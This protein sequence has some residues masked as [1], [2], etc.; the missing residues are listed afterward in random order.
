MILLFLLVALLVL[1][2]VFWCKFQKIRCGNMVCI[3]G[4]IK[5]GKSML[6]V[7]LVRQLWR[8][9]RLKAHIC[10]FFGRIFKGKK[11]KKREMPVIY[12]NVPLRLPYVPLTRELLTRQ[13]R[14]IYGSVVYVCEASLVADSM[15]YKDN[16]LN[17]LLLLFNKLFAHETHGGYIVY[18]TQSICDNHYAVK[19]CLNSYFYIHH[20][21]RI[22]FFCVLFMREERYSEDNHVQNVTSE[23]ADSGY[24]VKIIPKRVWKLYDR[25]CY[26]SFTDYLIRQDGVIDGKKADSMKAINVVSFK[27]YNYLTG[28]YYERSDK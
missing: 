17:E 23:N 13:V 11:Y 6:S 5:T 10:N 21:I 24:K 1:Y 18:D 27:R 2:L 9:Q 22:P 8:F 15:T 28:E 4:G 26:S 7:F 20:T 25:Y 19:R 12:S 14:F 16:E 3:T